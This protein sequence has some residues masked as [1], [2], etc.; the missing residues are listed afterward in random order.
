M[1]DQQTRLRQAII[2]LGKKTMVYLIVI[3]ILLIL[4]VRFLEQKSMFYPV[5]EI[6]N[7]PADVGLKYED[8]YFQTEDHVTL[9]AWLILHPEAKGTVL[10]FHGNAG[11]IGDRVTKIVLLYQMGVNV[12][13]PDYR[14]YGKSTGVPSEKGLNRDAQAAFDY[15][16][17][18]EDIDASHIVAYGV[19]LGGIFAIDLAS[20]RP[21][22]CLIVDSSISSAKDMAKL[23]YPMIPSVLIKAKLDSISKVKKLAMPKLFMHSQ[24]DEIIPFAIG[25]KL[26]DAAQEP[27]QFVTAH[28]G[29]NDWYLSD[30][31][32]FVK[33]MQQFLIENAIVEGEK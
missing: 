32:L 28:G 2:R 11:N 9:N 24:D 20:H 6:R 22:K 10:F 25:R 5:K 31:V 13:I 23:F 17:R 12:F 14:G 21:I 27:K 18:R 29:H 26:Y 3:C 30:E 7:T 19:S 16:D 4:V 33:S 8:V 1:S 15:L